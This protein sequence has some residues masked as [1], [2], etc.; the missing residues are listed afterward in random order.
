MLTIERKIYLENYLN[1]NYPLNITKKILNLWRSYFSEEEV[2]YLHR[3]YYLP[4]TKIKEAGSNLRLKMKLY[5]TPVIKEAIDYRFIEVDELLN[6]L[7]QVLKKEK[8]KS[9]NYEKLVRD[10][11]P[12][13]IKK[14]GSFHFIENLMMKNIG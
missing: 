6:Y 8:I 5:E 2:A 7:E 1:E 13:I 4:I 12:D 14:M 10:N 11:I 9:Q 3:A